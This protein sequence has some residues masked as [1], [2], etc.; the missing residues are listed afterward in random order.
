MNIA[1]IGKTVGEFENHIMTCLK[2]GVDLKFNQNTTN[3]D[4]ANWEAQCTDIF[5]S[6][7]Q[8]ISNEAYAQMQE[9]ATNHL[10][11]RG[12]S[13][14]EAE[15]IT[16]DTL[17]KIID[18]AE[19]MRQELPAVERA[20]KFGWLKFVGFVT[21]AFAGIMTLSMF[22]RDPRMDNA[23]KESAFLKHVQEEQQLAEIPIDASSM[24]VMISGL[25]TAPSAPQQAPPVAAAPIPYVPPAVAAIAAQPATATITTQGSTQT[26]Q[27]TVGQIYRYAPPPVRRFMAPPS[28]PPEEEE[29]PGEEYHNSFTVDSGF[30]SIS[31]SY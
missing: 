6:G 28:P 21:L 24:G 30:A 19:N 10:I 31:V 2:N 29:D 15:R 16:K 17:K 26:V 1:S 27:T 4:I 25:V 12:V 11:D 3:A 8:D 5:K 13:K 18:F 22:S 23:R 14:E 7:S 20:I 9:G